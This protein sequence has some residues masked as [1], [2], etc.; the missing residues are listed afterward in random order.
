VLAAWLVF[1][2]AI[3]AYVLQWK[4]AVICVM[5]AGLLVPLANYLF[6]RGELR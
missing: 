4:P 3:A 5:T 2:A 1:L 6:R